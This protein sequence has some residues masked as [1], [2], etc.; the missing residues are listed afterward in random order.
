MKKE[1]VIL[2]GGWAGL[3][4]AVELSSHGHQVTLFEKRGHLGGR[5]YSF[6]DPAS[7]S[8]LD[9]GQHL[10][11][12]CYSGT[13]RFLEKIGRLDDLHFQ[14]N[15]RVDLTGP[16]RNRPVRLQAWPLPAPWHL[17]GGLFGFQGFS[18]QE[19]VSFLNLRKA[20]QNEPLP[21]DIALPRWLEQ[22]G[23]SKRVQERF[24]NLLALAALNEEPRLCSAKLFQ[25]MLHEAFVSGRKGAVIGFSRVGLSDLYAE[26]AAEFIQKKGGHLFLKTAVT[27]LHF[28]GQELSE[29]EL[30]GGRRIAPEVVILAVPFSSLKKLLPESIL[31]KDPFFQPIHK[32]QSS[33]IVSINLWFDRDFIP[34][35]FLGFWGTSIHWLFN[36][37][38]ILHDK[39]APYYSV[40]MSGARNELLIPG[41]TLVQIALRELSQIFPEAAKAKLLHSHVMKEPEATLSPAVG[42]NPM[43]LPQ[44]T[45][46]KNLFLA[47][48]WTDTGLPATIE[49]AVR[50]AYRAVASVEG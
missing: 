4:A 39:G 30:E 44:R 48:D 32:L 26:P 21:T 49:G 11:M 14:N 42:V 41:P 10:F 20:L 12:G 35:D 37:G 17:L 43:R 50:S 15:F 1:I 47:G 22:M 18:L 7:G 23:Q 46:Y 9:N 13:K 38:Q 40:V 3:T 24:W 6:R 16:A 29:V 2:G 25:S 5:A 19:K 34:N 8:V 28:S 45:P 33:P 27:R 31:Y 36:K